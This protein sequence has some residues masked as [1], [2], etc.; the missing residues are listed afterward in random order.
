MK[1]L[2]EN[3]RDQTISGFS[4]SGK[5]LWRDHGT[6]GETAFSWNS[7]GVWNSSGVLRPGETLTINLPRNTDGIS[8]L[9]DE[10]TFESGFTWINPRLK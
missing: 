3:R 1:L 4:L 8:V 5:R 10:V 7:D 9:V 2:V 6:E